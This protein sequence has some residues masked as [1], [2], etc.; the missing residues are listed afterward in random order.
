MIGFDFVIVSL[1]IAVIM[2]VSSLVGQPPLFKIFIP[3]CF[4]ADHVKQ[5]QK[6]TRTSVTVPRSG[7]WINSSSDTGLDFVTLELN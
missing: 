1:R 3:L 5:P 4:G 7:E 6:R 2:I